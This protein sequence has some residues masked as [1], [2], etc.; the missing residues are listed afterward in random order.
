M[1]PSGRDISARR[2]SPVLP[3]NSRLTAD[4]DVER[5]TSTISRP[6]GSL[7]LTKPAR[8]DAGQHLLEH[9]AGQRVALGEV[10]IGPKR[11]L[12]FA[13]SSPRARALHTHTPAAQ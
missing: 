5:S 7:V 12:A 3:T 2:Y 13:V 6:T 1:S 8:R 4:F 10:H 9:D 11:H